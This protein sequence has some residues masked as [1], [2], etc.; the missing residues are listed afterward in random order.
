MFFN[1]NFELLFRKLLLP[2]TDV[3]KEKEQETKNY[4]RAHQKVCVNCNF[5]V[6]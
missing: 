2:I 5:S 6:Q 3:F 4:F 1:A